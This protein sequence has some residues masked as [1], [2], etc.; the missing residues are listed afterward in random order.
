[1][2]RNQEIADQLAGFSLFADLSTGQ[3]RGLVDQMEAIGL[4]GR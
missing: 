2:D 1:M 4:L 3:L